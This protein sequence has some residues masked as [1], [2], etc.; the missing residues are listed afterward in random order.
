MT[1]HEQI[2]EASKALKKKLDQHSRE[3]LV[4][5]TARLTEPDSPAAKE[6]LDAVWSE[7][8]QVLMEGK[9]IDLPEG[10]TWPKPSLKR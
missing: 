4:A 5:Y 10:Y 9:D 7:Y 6:Q 3:L 8:W 2:Q 1:D